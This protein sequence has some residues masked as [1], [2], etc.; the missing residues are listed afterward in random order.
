VA[1]V[2]VP[3]HPYAMYETVA[4]RDPRYFWIFFYCTQCGD[5]SRKQCSNPQRLSHWVLVYATNHGHNM[6]P[7]VRL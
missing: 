1:R 5:V 3:N 4:D 2:Q 7:Y 6:K